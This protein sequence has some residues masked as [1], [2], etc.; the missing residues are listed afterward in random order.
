MFARILPPI[1]DLVR[2]GWHAVDRRVAGWLRPATMGSLVVGAVAD[3]ARGKPELIAENALLRQQLI[4]LGRTTKRPR[5]TPRD[6]A[7]LVLLASRI[8]SRPILG[9]LHHVYE[10]T[11]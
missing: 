10:R 9:G 7:L 11:A 3:L 5:L 2:R 6:R 8:R 4:V 1:R